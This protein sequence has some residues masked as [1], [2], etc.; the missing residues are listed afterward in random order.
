MTANGFFQELQKLL[1]SQPKPE[2]LVLNSENC[3][4]GDHVFNSK[5]LTYCFDTSASSDSTYIFDCHLVARGQDCDYA[6]ESESCYECVDLYK[7]YNCYYGENLYNTH[8]AMYCY[9]LSN[10][11]DMFGCVSLKN[12]SYCIFNRQFTKEEYEKEVLKYK[13]LPAEKALAMLEELKL[14]YPITQSITARNVNSPYGNYVYDSK[15]CY[16]CFDVGRSEDS[17]YL[18]DCGDAKKSMD[19]SYTYQGTSNSYQIVDSITIY[20]GNFVLN[21]ENCQDSSYL[22]NCKG[23][24]NS[25]GCVGLQYKEYCILN[26]QFSKEE[27][28]QLA[29][30]IKKVLAAS[31][32]NWSKIT[33]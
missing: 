14:R 8:D 31:D 2:T 3:F 7:C 15:N 23:V 27:Y 19:M 26:R 29:S 20:N 33:V 5:N 22:F 6:V 9:D 32:Y 24:K 4:Y 21:S 28:E 10:C 13:A 30:E 11:H 17:S 16:M 25:L 1:D 18:Y 12:K